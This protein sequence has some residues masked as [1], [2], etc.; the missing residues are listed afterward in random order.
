MNINE[1]LEYLSLVDDILKHKEFEKTKVINHHGLN[2]YDHSV[3]VS[4]SSYKVAKFLRLDSKE[5]ARAGLLHDF[6]LVNN[7][8]ISPTEKINTVINHPRYAVAYSEK[9]F[10]LNEKEKDIIKTHMFPI[11]INLIPKYAE[12]WIVNIVDNV[13]AIYE[14]IYVKNKVLSRYANV[15]LVALIKFMKY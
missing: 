3:R 2:R 13:V 9:F 14:Q 10:K 15:F 1:D 6:F 12:S 7:K 8:K 4:Y 11:S 5:V